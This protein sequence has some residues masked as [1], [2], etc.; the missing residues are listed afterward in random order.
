MG[1][2]LGLAATAA[3]FVAGTA[4]FACAAVYRLSGCELD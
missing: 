1:W 2:I 3:V 4:G